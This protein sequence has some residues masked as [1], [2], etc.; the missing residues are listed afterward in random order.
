MKLSSSDILI[1]LAAFLLITSIILFFVGPEFIKSRYYDLPNQEIKG[2]MGDSFGGTMGPVIAWIAAILTFA[3]FY[4]QYEANKEQRS[5]F[6]KQADDTVIERFEN[7]F[8]ELIRL[9]RE[10]VQEQNIQDIIT[11]R[12]V[13]TTYYFELRYIYFVLESTHDTH[14]PVS[15]LTKEELTN[16]AYLIF[17]FGIGHTTQ[18][19][20]AHITPKY[21]T[22]AFFIQTLERLEREKSKYRKI[23]ADIE[24]AKTRPGLN[25]PS[26]EDLVIEHNGK[27]AVF[28]QVYQPF[29]G[30]GTK[31]G[32][33]FRHLFQTVKYVANQDNPLF[34]KK[35]KYSYV[36][37]LRAQLSNFEQI[38][39]YYNSISLLGEAWLKNGY[40]KDYKLIINLPLS[41]ADFGMQ[42]EEKFE[43]EILAD[44]KF[45][46]WNTLKDSL[47]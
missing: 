7:R 29:T 15:P 10:N 9:H 12:K 26:H 27:K 14:S 36:K 42:P 16:L 35:L 3:A 1:S 33:Y 5:Q 37:I 13:F 20:F 43:N 18:S 11:G 23:A 46:D 24:L 40:I 21:V 22:E 4:I 8:F 19:V 6:A 41:F 17:F 2:Q 47:S 28:M 45:F 32:H 39:F 38:I 25:M 31:I 30:H 44:K 34:T